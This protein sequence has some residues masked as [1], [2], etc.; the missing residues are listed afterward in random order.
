MT[1]FDVA[2]ECTLPR[3][4]CTS[5]LLHLLLRF[6]SASGPQVQGQSRFSDVATHLFLINNSEL[7]LC[8]NICI[9]EKILV[10]YLTRIL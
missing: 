4:T 10:Y 1:Y 8:G 5:A 9:S 7:H 3:Y 6:M 2:L